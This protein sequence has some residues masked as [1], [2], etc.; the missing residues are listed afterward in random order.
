MGDRQFCELPPRQHGPHPRNRGDIMRN[1]IRRIIRVGTGLG[2]L[3]ATPLFA[4]TAAAPQASTFAAIQREI[5]WRAAPPKI[6]EDANGKFVGWL[7]GQSFVERKVNGVWVGIPVDIGF[8]ANPL[9]TS[10]Q[11]FFKSSDCSGPKYLDARG[12][13]PLGYVVTN[14]PSDTTPT[15]LFPGTPGLLSI[16]SRQFNNICTTGILQLWVGLVQSFN[17]NSLGL[18]PPFTVK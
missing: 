15:L 1:L 12:L 18:V 8:S 16:G 17:L 9:Q 6:V 14:P 10:V 4:Q 7:L 11:F 5:E 2:L 13:P 3:F